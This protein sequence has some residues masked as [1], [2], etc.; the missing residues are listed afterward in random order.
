MSA[1]RALAIAALV[2]LGLLALTG[3]ESSIVGTECAAPLVRC[4]RFC[5]DLQTDGLNC[6]VCGN[7]CAVSCV[8]GICMV[9]DASVPPDAGRDAGHHDAGHDAATHDTGTDAGPDASSDAGSD[10]AD[11][12][13]GGPRCGLGELLCGTSCVDPRD[14]TLCGDCATTCTGT[15]VCAAGACAPDCG[16]MLACGT[17][18]V[19]PTRDAHHC[20]DCATD[21]GTD[22]CTAAGCAAPNPGHVVLIGHDFETR[23]LAMSTML[24]NAIFL[25]TRS[26]VHLLAYEVDSSAAA[27]AGTD[28]AI[29]ESTP[30]APLTITVAPSADSVPLLLDDTDTLLVYAQANASDVTLRSIGYAWRDALEDFLERGGVIVV[31]EAPSLSNGGTYQILEEAGL[32]DAVSVSELVMPR[33]VAA[34][35]RASDPVLASVSFPYV[36]ERHSARISSADPDV[37]VTTG[38][39]PVVFHRVVT[40]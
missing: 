31:L 28:A 17:R 29:A 8:T 1:P 9:P 23:R 4:G 21:C 39:D 14:A 30:G 13:G 40:Q 3:C 6:G 33:L 7:A 24:G 27:I 34:T 12:D 20:G 22:L 32:F 35:G 37:I 18:C 15:D 36:G 25:T 26:T 10:A 5:V 11:I 2:A 16:T 38:T 19:D